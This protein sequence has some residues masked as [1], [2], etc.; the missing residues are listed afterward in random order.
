[1]PGRL[2]R[3]LKLRSVIAKYFALEL[4]VY[5]LYFYIFQEGIVVVGISG[6]GESATVDDMV[7]AYLPEAFLFIYVFNSVNVG[8]I[9]WV[10]SHGHLTVPYLQ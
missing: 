7:K 9:H 3:F 2:R 10:S 8:G 6:V 5:I 4:I 1:M